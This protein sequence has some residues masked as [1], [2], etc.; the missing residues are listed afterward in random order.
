VTTTV[1]DPVADTVLD[2]LV[3][4]AMTRSGHVEPCDGKTLEECVTHFRGGH[5]L[6]YN[7]ESHSTRMVEV[8]E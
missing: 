7:D 8:E 5:Q 2:R 4:E 3:R 1:R 6:W